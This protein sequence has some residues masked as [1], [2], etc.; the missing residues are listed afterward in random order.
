[1]TSVVSAADGYGQ[2]REFQS[3]TEG[4]RQCRLEGADS[5]PFVV[6]T[7]LVGVVVKV[8]K[9]GPIWRK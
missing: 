6:R 4:F 7:R 8:S 9:R 3:T 2:V 1:M 5:L